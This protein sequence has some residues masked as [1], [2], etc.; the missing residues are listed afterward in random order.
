MILSI[1]YKI[2]HLRS[3]RISLSSLTLAVVSFLV[4]HLRVDVIMNSII[5]FG[6]CFLSVHCLQMYT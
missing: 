6:T 5:V 2:K 4:S 3:Y 1:S